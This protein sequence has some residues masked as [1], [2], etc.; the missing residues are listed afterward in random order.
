MSAQRISASRFPLL[1]SVF[2]S[3]F[4]FRSQLPCT[5]PQG[6]STIPYVTSHGNELGRHWANNEKCKSYQ[7]H[8]LPPAC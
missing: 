4:S 6:T 5:K 1:F 8:P 3:R 2:C 7:S